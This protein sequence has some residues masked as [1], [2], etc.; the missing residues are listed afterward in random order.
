MKI[1]SLLLV[2]FFSVGLVSVTAQDKTKSDENRR[3]RIEKYKERKAEFLKKE[4]QLT[5]AE[6]AAFIPLVNELM[7]KK[8]EAN[9][10]ARMNIRTM[11]EKKDK[12]DSDYK[13]AIDGMLNSQIK[14][15]ELQ[16]EYYQKFMK[17]LP[18]EK[19]YKYHEAE[20]K[21]MKTTFEK[22]DRL[23]KD[24]N[25]PSDRKKQDGNRRGGERS[26][27]SSRNK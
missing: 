25:S 17:V 14:E 1:K 27:N 20:M 4:L 26:K 23:H 2:L 5:D 13:A 24:S 9:R 3:D 12:T 22:H 6:A 19:V 8:Y 21:F 11:R 15:A 7:D 16:K 18:M 10:N